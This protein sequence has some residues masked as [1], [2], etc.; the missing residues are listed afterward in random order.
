MALVGP[1]YSARSMTSPMFSSVS[2]RGRACSQHEYHIIIMPREYRVPGTCYYLAARSPPPLL[3]YPFRRSLL[4]VA[5]PVLAVVY[6]RIFFRRVFP[7]KL[8]GR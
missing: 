2:I 1:V 3:D 7:T 5:E 4:R 6:S 8:A